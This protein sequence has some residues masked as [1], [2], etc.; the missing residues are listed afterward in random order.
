MVRCMPRK[1]LLKDWFRRL[2][3]NLFI[4]VTETHPWK[5][6]DWLQDSSMLMIYVGTKASCHGNA[7]LVARTIEPEQALWHTSLKISDS[8]RESV[9]LSSCNENSRSSASMHLMGNAM[10]L[11][12][13]SCQSPTCFSL[14]QINEE[15]VFCQQ[16]WCSWPRHLSSSLGI[17]S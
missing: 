8:K 2:G 15:L 7:H 3:K 17:S 16:W 14:L 13:P 1:I 11:T 9:F 5:Q 12:V 6:T 4:Q 10:I